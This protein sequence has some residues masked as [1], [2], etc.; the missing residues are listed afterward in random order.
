MNV[1]VAPTRANFSLRQVVSMLGLPAH[2][3]RG[4]IEAGFVSPQRGPRNAYQFDFRDIVL[5]RTAHRLRA[6][7]IKPAKLLQSLA[8]LKASL[9]DELPLTGLRITA[10]G[11]DVA[12]RDNG[13][14]VAADTGQLLMD[15]EVAPAGGAV[16]LLDREPEREPGPEPA[17]SSGSADID[18]FERGVA[19]EVGDPAG[20]EQ[21]YRQALAADA[22]DTD[23]YLN[24]S[25]LLCAAGRCDEA[26]TVLDDATQRLSDEP[27]LH[28]NH[29]IALEDQRRYG[30]A[31]AAYAR[32]LALDPDCA[33]AHYNLARL[34]ERSGEPQRALRHLQAYRR[35]QG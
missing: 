28:F 20:A 29:A 30:A 22:D 2:V 34:H 26:V 14:Q 1:S 8:R 10:V 31:I 16:A 15:L 33:D 17:A 23:A 19:L 27:L 11:S 7:H 35:L 25:A 18:W 21:A 32:C 5:L 12:V 3:V 9:P 6:A 13:V 4:L 24:L